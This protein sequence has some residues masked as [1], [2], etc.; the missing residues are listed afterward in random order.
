MGLY[1]VIINYKIKN[2]IIEQFIKNI[3]DCCLVNKQQ[4]RHVLKCY[5][6]FTRTYINCFPRDFN[7]E[8]DE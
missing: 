7:L 6:N 1:R 3:P 8:E 2:I 5:D 4:V